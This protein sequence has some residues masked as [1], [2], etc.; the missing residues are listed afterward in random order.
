MTVTAILQLLG[1]STGITAI[2]FFVMW[3]TG[4]IHTKAEL[5]DKQ[6]QI[7]ELKE[8]I[9]LERTRGDSVVLTGQ[10]VRDVMTSL[11]KEIT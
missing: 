11:H 1:G 7:D 3:L 4:L 10:I 2:S 8:T 9:K 6:A 5:D